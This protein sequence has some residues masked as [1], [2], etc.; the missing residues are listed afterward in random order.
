MLKAEGLTV[1]GLR[2]AVIHTRQKLNT[3]ERHT[4]LVLGLSRSSFR[5]Q[6]K[7][8]SDDELRLAM[9][10]LAKQYGRY[11]Y[12]KVTALLRMEGWRFNHKK[13][14]RLWSEGGLQLPNRHNKRRQLYHKTKACTLSPHLDHRLRSRKA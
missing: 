7:S 13:I 4:C 1:D 8:T 2:Q 11:G 9:I 3:S 10:R 5:Y 14:E 6:V 12:R